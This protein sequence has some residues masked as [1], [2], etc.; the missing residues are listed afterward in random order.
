MSSVNLHCCHHSVS[1]PW[2]CVVICVMLPCHCFTQN[3]PLNVCVRLSFLLLPNLPQ[4]WLLQSGLINVASQSEINIFLVIVDVIRPY[5]HGFPIYYEHFHFW[6]V[7]ISLIWSSGIWLSYF[8]RPSVFL[9][10]KSYCGQCGVISYTLLL[11]GYIIHIIQ[12]S[13]YSHF[14]PAFRS[15]V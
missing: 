5:K 15:P 8:W 12:L 6:I 14:P 13:V 1:L 3:Y 10:Q 4:T 7:L 9:L 2:P 11:Y